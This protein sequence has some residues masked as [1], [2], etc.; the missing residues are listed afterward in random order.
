MANSILFHFQKK[1]VGEPRRFFQ[2]GTDENTA[3]RGGPKSRCQIRESEN[4]HGAWSAA[5][6]IQL[7]LS[8]CY[9]RIE[10]GSGIEI[11]SPSLPVAVIHGRLSKYSGSRSL[12]FKA[13]S[14]VRGS[15]KPDL[16]EILTSRAVPLLLKWAG[17]S[18]R[19]GWAPKDSCQSCKNNA[20]EKQYVCNNKK[21]D[22]NVPIGEGIEKLKEKYSQ[23]LRKYCR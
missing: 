2:F 10:F 17:W 18:C 6:T 21:R 11:S 23:I 5:F 9:I 4:E 7:A 14:K 19:V 12:P 15:L 13:N 3:S 16:T 8:P 22:S 1:F 20:S